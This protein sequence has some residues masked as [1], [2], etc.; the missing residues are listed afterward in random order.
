MLADD[1]HRIEGVGDLLGAE[2]VKCSA[3]V[4]DSSGLNGGFRSR[5]LAAQIGQHSPEDDYVALAACVD[6]SGLAE[7]GVEVDGIF[8]SFLAYFEGGLEHLFDVAALLCV[9]HRGGGGHARDGQYSALGGL[10]DRLVGRVD[11]VLH[12]GGKFL[13][14]DR[15]HTLEPAGNAAE[16]QGQDNAGVAA[17]AAQQRACNAVGH[18]VNGVKVL[19]PELG[20]RRVKGEAHICARIAVGNGENVQFVYLLCIRCKRRVS[21]Q[22]HIFKC[23]GVNIFSQSN[24]TSGRDLYIIR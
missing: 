17:G 13:C 23:C 21:T 2:N 3:F 19:F 9:F 18:R 11:A 16:E 6:N 15:L 14:A 8:K 12:C 22:Y 7:N 10:H 24:S 5:D 4:G 1:E 20:S